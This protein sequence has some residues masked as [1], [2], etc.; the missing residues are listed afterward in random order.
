[1]A[2]FL[3]IF[4]EW[5]SCTSALLSFSAREEQKT[6][7]GEMGNL[8]KV[9]DALDESLHFFGSS[10]LKMA[11]LP[12][13]EEKRIGRL[14][15]RITELQQQLSELCRRINIVLESVDNVEGDSH[16]NSLTLHYLFCLHN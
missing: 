3:W 11:T 5:I 15:Q 16:L 2:W 10:M 1:M 13:G 9:W 12:K 6:Q 7:E 8:H 14:C 4:I